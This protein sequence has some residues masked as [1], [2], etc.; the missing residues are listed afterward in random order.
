MTTTL[1]LDTHIFL[2]LMLKDENLSTSELNIIDQAAQKNALFVSA[3]SIW[4]IALLQ[5][6]GRIHLYQQ[7]LKWVEEALALPGINLAPLDPAI[8]CESV[9]LPEELRKDPADRM[10]IATARIMKLRLMT[11][12]QKILDY[13]AQGLLDCVS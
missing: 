7:P 1:L 10:I 13:A 2:W 11:H 9:A 12:D 4:E 3:I 8:L 5:K 6:R